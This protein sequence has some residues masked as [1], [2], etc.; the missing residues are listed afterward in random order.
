MGIIVEDQCQPAHVCGWDGLGLA[1]KFSRWRR[2][3]KRKADLYGQLPGTCWMD[4]RPDV[5]LNPFQLPRVWTPPCPPTQDSFV[6]ELAHLKSSAGAWDNSGVKCAVDPNVGYCVE[7]IV[8]L[9]A[10]TRLVS[11]EQR[12]MT[13]RGKTQ[14][15]NTKY[16]P[17]THLDH[18]EYIHLV[19]MTIQ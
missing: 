15:V 17:P 2:C 8:S 19:A 14:S 5:K 12:Q 10:A 11:G 4:R 18:K 7:A 6:A 3:F 16:W 1:Q 13:S 9:I